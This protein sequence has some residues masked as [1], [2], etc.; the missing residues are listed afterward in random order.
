MPSAGVSGH[1]KWSILSVYIY[2]YIYISSIYI[3]LKFPSW[4]DP[5]QPRPNTEPFTH[6]PKVDYDPMRTLIHQ[7]FTSLHPSL[8]S[9]NNDTH[10]PWDAPWF[11][12]CMTLLT[13][14]QDHKGDS[15]VIQNQVCQTTDWWERRKTSACSQLILVFT[16]FIYLQLF[17]CESWAIKKAEPKNWCFPTVV[18][19]KI[20]E[21]P[22]DCK[23]IQPVHPKGNQS[24]IFIGRTDA[25]AETPILQP[26]DGKKWLIIGKDP[27]AGKDWRQDR[28]WDGWMASPTQWTWAWANSGRWWRTGKPGRPQSMGLQRVP[29]DHFSRAP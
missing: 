1:I 5:V 9:H 8:K 29:R 7:H 13:A 21:S 24:W 18:L 23:E 26:P 16:H 11:R 27:D 2:I 4:Q 6:G 28:G 3:N 14:G 25:E 22:L 20:L 10:I 19:E 17:R 15:V 12:H